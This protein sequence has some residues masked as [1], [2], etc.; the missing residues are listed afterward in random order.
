MITSTFN[1]EDY[2]IHLAIKDIT[3]EKLGIFRGIGHD[4][5]IFSFVFNL[6]LCKDLIK[7]SDIEQ[8]ERY[9]VGLENV[10]RQ[11]NLLEY[12]PNSLIQTKGTSQDSRLL[13]P[14]MQF[15]NPWDIEI[16]KLGKNG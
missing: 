6:N 4:A 7:D 13:K 14:E 1:R 11:E 9:Q 3:K 15:I 2:R 10:V 5:E 16:P 8:F 12:A